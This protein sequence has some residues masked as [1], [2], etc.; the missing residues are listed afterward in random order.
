MLQLRVRASDGGTPN[1]T[2]TA[3]VHIHVNRNE[4]APKFDTKE[5]KRTILE[6][7]PLGIPFT[8]I[9][10]RDQDSKVGHFS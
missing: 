6:T 10:A 8:K 5:Y 1:L 2:D 9:S 3:L 7:Q 4:F